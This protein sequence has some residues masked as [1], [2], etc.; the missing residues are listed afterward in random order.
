MVVVQIVMHILYRHVRALED[1]SAFHRLRRSVYLDN[2]RNAIA[3]IELDRPI[4]INVNHLLPRYLVSSG[5]HVNCQLLMRSQRFSGTLQS[6]HEVFCR[7]FQPLDE[8]LEGIERFLA[9]CV[10]RGH[11]RRLPAPV[12]LHR[13]QRSSP[14]CQPVIARPHT[15]ACDLSI[16][17]IRMHTLGGCIW[18]SLGRSWPW[19]SDVTCRPSQSCP[20]LSPSETFVSFHQRASRPTR[21]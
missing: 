2:R 7:V 5:G 10:P 11:R 3:R 15:D 16:S 6:H 1:R 12:G 8:P 4:G 14:A 18:T 20:S 9:P 19:V 17:A 21:A 13:L